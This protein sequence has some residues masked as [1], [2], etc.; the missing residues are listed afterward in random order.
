MKIELEDMILK[1]IGSINP[2]GETNTD[3]ERYENLKEMTELIDSL[4]GYVAEV[5]QNKDRHEYSMK[6][7]GEHVEDFFKD[8]KDWLGDYE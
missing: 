8:I 4:L 7:A 6:R 1:L 3:N 2:I 5:Y